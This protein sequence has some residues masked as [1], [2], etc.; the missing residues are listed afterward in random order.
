MDDESL[1]VSIGKTL[2]SLFMNVEKEKKGKIGATEAQVTIHFD[3]S[4]EAAKPA[5]PAP[6]HKDSSPMLPSSIDWTNAALQITDHFTVGDALTLHSWNRLA[7]EQ[8]GLTDKIKS[9]ILF[10][11]GKM[12]EVR[13]TLGCPINVHCTYRSPDYNAQVVKAIPHDVHSMGMAMDF[14][15]N[16][17]KTIDEVHAILEPLLDQLNMRM[18]RNTA[19]WVHLDIHP[20]GNARYFNA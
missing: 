5:E 17:H 13:G 9:S 7:T 10:L 18:E 14:D 11:F 4:T 8:D 19:T 2:L 3:G 20:V 6:P 12:E 16:G 1:L 15:C